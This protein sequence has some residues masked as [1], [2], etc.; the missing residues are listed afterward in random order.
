MFRGQF[1]NK[2][3]E[4]AKKDPRLFMIT[5][6]LGFKLFDNFRE[7]CPEQ[8]MNI[9]VAEANMMAVGAGM[10][11][12]GKNVFVY[13]MV[14]FVTSRAHDQ[15]RVDVSGHNL[16]VKIVGVG[17]GVG[18]GLEGMTHLALDDISWMRSL[19]NMSIVC[20]ADTKE[21]DALLPTI[22]EAQHP[23][24]VRLIKGQAPDIHTQELKAISIGQGLT[25]QEG[26]DV[27][28]LSFGS[29]ISKCLEAAAQLT[30]EKSWKVGVYSFPWIKPIDKTLLKQIADHYPIVISMEEH[31]EAGG[32]G[33]IVAENLMEMGYKG[34]FKKVAF[35]DKLPEVIGHGPYLCEWAGVTTK[36]LIEAIESVKAQL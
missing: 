12:C 21:M 34:K 23:V 22:I 15:I 1:I 9:G 30:A 16:A 33:T 20:P 8:F 6:D 18:Y 10:A 28:L 36:G 3:K 24:Y 32:F 13:S 5:A 4:Y 2:L 35:P 17:A 31:S 26:K 29:G 27:A 7:E 25:V 11:L 19:P 14:P